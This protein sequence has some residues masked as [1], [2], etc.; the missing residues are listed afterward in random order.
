MIL[1]GFS[2]LSGVLVTAMVAPVLA[3]T[4]NVGQ[5]SIGIFDNPPDYI[6]LGK[7]SQQNLIYANRNGAPVQIATIYNQDRQDVSWKAVSP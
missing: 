4:G 1:V 2:M 6:T 3:I 5:A 7:L